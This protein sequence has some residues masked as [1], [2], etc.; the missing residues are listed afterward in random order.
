[1]LH[2]VVVRIATP[3]MERYTLGPPL[4]HHGVRHHLAGHVTKLLSHG[5]IDD[6]ECVKE[7]MP[8]NEDNIIVSPRAM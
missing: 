6:A 2:D 8:G 4:M 7:Y 1:M 5:N 3:A